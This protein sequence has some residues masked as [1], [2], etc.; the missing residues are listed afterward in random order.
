MEADPETGKV[1]GNYGNAGSSFTEG[2]YMF[3]YDKTSRKAS[4]VKWTK[5]EFPALAAGVDDPEKK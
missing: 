3:S 2:L 4:L 5:T 1:D